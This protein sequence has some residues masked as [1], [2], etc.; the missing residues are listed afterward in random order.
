MN[1]QELIREI[2][3]VTG[4]SQRVVSL[5]LDALLETIMKTVARG[6]KVSIRGLGTFEVQKPLRRQGR[7]PQTG[8]A[9]A[10][11]VKIVFT[12]VKSL[13]SADMEAP[14]G[15]L[16]TAKARKLAKPK[17]H[18]DELK[19][20]AI[21]RPAPG[22]R[23]MTGS[24]PEGKPLPK[25][26][27]G[28]A[29]RV[30]YA[31][32]RKQTTHKEFKINYSNERSEGGKLYYGSCL[33]SVPKKL[34]HTRGKLERPLTIPIFK[35]KINPDPEKYFLLMEVVS[36]D[37]AA[38]F[39]ELAGLVEAT[40]RKGVFVF[41]H[42]FNV[43]FEHAALVTAQLAVD[44]RLGCVPVFYSWPSKGKLAA[45]VQDAGPI[46][47]TVR[48]LM[49]FLTLLCTRSGAQEIYLMAHSMGNRA[50]CNALE[51]I[52]EQQAGSATY[53]I[54]QL[55]LTAPDVDAGIFRE[56]AANLKAIAQRITLY[57]SEKDKALMASRR[58]NG[59]PRAGGKPLVILPGLV[60]TIDASTVDTNFLSSNHSYVLENRTVM[61]DIWELVMGNLPPSKRRELLEMT[62]PD[63][64]YYCFQ[65]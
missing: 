7:N 33:V 31:T 24:M 46:D 49:K 30:Y 42:G 48:H 54:Q 21:A 36:Q 4:L 26:E 52:C 6:H 29:I 25:P 64:T 57:A 53:R 60:D 61:N 5:V 51:R 56:A 44:L 40:E 35:I 43:S 15:G 41:V 47:A 37:E 14:G 12:P 17:S 59:F 55:I 18:L 38:Y 10:I 23:I 39:S 13:G 2:S 62:N 22:G 50:V 3:R 1:R 45:Y 65:P 27:D 63:G 11:A 8:I 9:T 58:I 28:K 32:D 34:F 20:H 19:K 16:V